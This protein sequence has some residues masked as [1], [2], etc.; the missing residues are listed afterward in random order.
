MI[1]SVVPLQREIM[2]DLSFDT[3]YA[4]TCSFS[5]NVVSQRWY[6][7]YFNEWYSMLFK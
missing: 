4:M 6:D 2:I 1:K 7:A 5:E 3:S